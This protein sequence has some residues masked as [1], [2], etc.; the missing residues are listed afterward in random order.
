MAAQT[1]VVRPSASL[2]RNVTRPEQSAMP[3][4]NTSGVNRNPPPPPAGTRL[5]RM[6][7]GT[8]RGA[9]AGA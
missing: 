9:S 2:L 3:R 1:V 6:C 4:A 8:A 7:H 5:Q